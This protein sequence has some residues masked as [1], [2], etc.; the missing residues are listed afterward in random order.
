MKILQ[1]CS[2]TLDRKITNMPFMSL[3]GALINTNQFCFITLG[4]YTMAL[5]KLENVFYFY[6]SHSQNELG[7]SSADGTAVL[8]THLDLQGCCLFIRHLAATILPKH[9]DGIFK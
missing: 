7:M 4:C 5:M 3:E 1:S 6:D 9:T 2:G 8:T